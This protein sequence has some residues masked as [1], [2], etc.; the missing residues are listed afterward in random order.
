[1]RLVLDMGFA[2]KTAEFLRGAG[3]DCIHLHERRL[4]T[5]PD[6][7]IMALAEAEDRVLVTADLDFPR[8]LAVQKKH[9]PSVILFRLKWFNTAMANQRL[10]EVLTAFATE[11]AR[12][13]IVT[14]EENR[15]RARDLPL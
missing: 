6:D 2:P 8:L 15:N 7:Q 3:H 5:L 13:A 1:M 10:T 11:L 12:G 9:R 4:D 14:V